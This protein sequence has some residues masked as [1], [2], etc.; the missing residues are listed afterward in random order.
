MYTT[1]RANVIII[2]KHVHYHTGQT[3]FP[4]LEDW[5][6]QINNSPS[7]LLFSA[8]REPRKYR[9]RKEKQRI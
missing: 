3:L 2:S 7:K 9:K 6:T 5:E 1:V 4:K 8:E